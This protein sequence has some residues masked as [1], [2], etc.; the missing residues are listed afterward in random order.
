MPAKNVLTSLAWLPKRAVKKALPSLIWLYCDS[1]EWK[2][3]QVASGKELLAA[4][5]K[6]MYLALGKG[7]NCID[8]AIAW[9]LK[10][11]FHLLALV[12]C[13]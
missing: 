11:H 12:V 8:E 6:V 7:L 2:L 1:R 3:E 5:P 9:I 13:W 10:V 4:I